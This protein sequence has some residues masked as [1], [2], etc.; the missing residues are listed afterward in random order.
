MG[1][2]SAFFLGESKTTN[3]DKNEQRKSTT[4]KKFLE[5]ISKEFLPFFAASSAASGEKVS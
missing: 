4:K 5:K 2:Q 1:D 3:G